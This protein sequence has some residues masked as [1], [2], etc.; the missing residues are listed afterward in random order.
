MRSLLA[1]STVVLALTVV[2]TL[3]GTALATK[4][5]PETVVKN[6]GGGYGLIV[7]QLKVS[8]IPCRTGAQVAYGFWNKRN[9]HGWRCRTSSQPRTLCHRGSK[10]ASFVFGGDAG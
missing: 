6:D 1:A 10:R 7:S 9:M 3:P 5:C 8:G 4:R 2:G